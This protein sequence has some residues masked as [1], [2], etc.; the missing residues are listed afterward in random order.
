MSLCGPKNYAYMGLKQ[1][2]LNRDMTEE[3]WLPPLEGADQLFS[4]SILL[5]LVIVI[6]RN[7]QISKKTPDISVSG[8]DQASR[9]MSHHSSFSLV[10][11]TVDLPFK[12]QLCLCPTHISDRL[13]PYELEGRQGLSGRAL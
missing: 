2:S 11:F 4:S 10:S 12:A 6:V 7:K 8:H 5:E 1:C 13:M 3:F 9:K